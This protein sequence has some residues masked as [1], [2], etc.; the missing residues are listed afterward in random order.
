ML[1]MVHYPVT[2]TIDTTEQNCLW[3]ICTSGV[4]FKVCAFEKEIEF[5][6]DFDEI[7]SKY[8]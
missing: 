4:L 7:K 8:A 1:L 6:R 2:L 3:A 5:S